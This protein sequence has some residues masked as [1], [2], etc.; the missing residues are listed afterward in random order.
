MADPVVLTADNFKAEVLDTPGVILVDFW[1]SWC[2]PCRMV[3][4]LVAQLAEELD[5][6]AR[7]GKLDIDEHAV[8]AAEYGVMSIPTLVLFKDGQEVERVIGLKPYE[9]LR[10]L[11]EAQL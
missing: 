9:T 4:P 2:G 8:P 7:V 3:A 11:M 5:G 10:T 6:R 1:A